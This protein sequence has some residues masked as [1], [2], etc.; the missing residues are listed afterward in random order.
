MTGEKRATSTTT[1][2]TVALEA[3]DAAKLKQ[4]F[5]DGR[6]ADIGII[7]I[8]FLTE[9]ESQDVYG[10]WTQKQ[11]QKGPQPDSEKPGPA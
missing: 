11:A 9:S 7:N 5:A 8:K 4:A 6:L 1:V 3:E 10:K 2:I